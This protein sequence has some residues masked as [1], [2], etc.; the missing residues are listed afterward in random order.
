MVIPQ[1]TRGFTIIELLIVIVVIAILAAITTVVFS[2]VQARAEATRVLSEADT[3]KKAL[4]VYRIQ[5]G[6]PALP[7][8]ST[9]CLGDSLAAK[10]DF[11][12]N[13][14]HIVDGVPAATSTSATLMANLR[15]QKLTI[16]SPENVA[17]TADYTDYGWGTWKFR[18]IM[19]NSLSGNKDEVYYY[20][21]GDRSC[22]S[23]SKTYDAGTNVTQCS[24]QF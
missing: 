21:S 17:V 2:G 4:Q 24:I 23:F 19:Y 1:H 12:A 20:I 11:P 13:R 7:V 8:G 22:G 3:W 5:T 9:V 16:P 6:S 18:G 15:A 14:C 10:D